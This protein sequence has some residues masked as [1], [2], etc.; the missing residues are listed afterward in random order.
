MFKTIT[1]FI[2]AYGYGLSV[3]S[4]KKFGLKCDN[5]EMT[6]TNKGPIANQNAAGIMG[7]THGP[8]YEIFLYPAKRPI[9]QSS[10]VNPFSKGKKS[11]TSKED[12]PFN[13]R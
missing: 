13:T 11:R 6:I 5:T 3:V 2:P 8:R 12:E 4:S 1:S 9:F 10:V 7:S